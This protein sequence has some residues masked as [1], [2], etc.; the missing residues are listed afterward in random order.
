[1]I[2]VFEISLDYSLMPALMLGSVVSILI[3]GQLHAESIYTEP[4][5]QRGLELAREDSRTGFVT[6][7]TVGD[8]MHAPV[9]PLREHASL[10]EIAG[11]FLGSA[12][13][14]LPVVDGQQKLVGVVALH[15]L[16][17]HLNPGS[18]QTLI[19]AHDVMRPPPKCLTPNLPLL[20]AL[21]IVLESEL[22]NIPVVNSYK[23]NRLVGSLARAEVLAIFS[24]AIAAESK[25]IG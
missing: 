5:R 4:L 19:I 25:V 1:M 14:Y 2:M 15:D 18:E 23:E 9:P 10:R 17:E 24:E 3:A 12:L 7:Q 13:N 11:R 20:Q 22:R 6:G 8:L 21:P 16:K